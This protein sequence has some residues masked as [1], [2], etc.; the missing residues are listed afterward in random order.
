ELLLCALGGCSGMDVASILTKM[1]LAF[2]DIQVDVE[3]ELSAQE[4]RRLERAHMRYRIWGAALTPEAVE[5]A[6]L[7]SHETYCTIA[8]TLRPATRITF[9]WA[10]NPEGEVARAP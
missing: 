1:R 10:L 5:R 2:D 7:L 6:V 4:P 3:G 8:N 9:E